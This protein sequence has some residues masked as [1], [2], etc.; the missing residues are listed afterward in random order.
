MKLLP[1]VYLLLAAFCGVSANAASN[2]EIHDEPHYAQTRYALSR[3]N[4]KLMWTV[5]AT[6]A[7]AFSVSEMRACDLQQYGKDVLPQLR[8]ELLLALQSGRAGLQD[9][10]QSDSLGKP[11]KPI[12]ARAL[13]DMHSLS[14]G[15]L[16]E[17][18][19]W[20]LALQQALATDPVWRAERS[21]PGRSQ[22]S[23]IL[24]KR[25]IEVANR[26]AVFADLAKVFEALGYT[27]YLR[28]IEKMRFL[29]DGRLLDCQLFFGLRPQIK[30]TGVM[31]P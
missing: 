2:L 16:E 17:L 15:R 24:A 10:S 12:P 27:L 11:L 26:D 4:C 14:V 9:G 13:A 22:N 6:Q 28:N 30:P 7:P 19:Q 29:P 20:Q 3:E 1:F 5:R 21:K 31:P 18:P 23:L 8:G 25:L